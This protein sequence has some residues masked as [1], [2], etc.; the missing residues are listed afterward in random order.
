MLA[1]SAMSRTDAVAEVE[2]YIAM[3]GQALAYKVGQLTIRRLR[4]QAE[5]ALG[6]RFDLRAFH[7]EVLMT[8]SIPLAVLE[9]KIEDWIDASR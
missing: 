3:P 1:H 7:A 2:R 9:R 4:R 6:P 5:Q 8:G